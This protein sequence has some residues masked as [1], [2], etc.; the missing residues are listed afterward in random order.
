MQRQVIVCSP[1]PPS[2]RSP[3]P[4]YSLILLFRFLPFGVPSWPLTRDSPFASI[5]AQ[6]PDMRRHNTTS[7]LNRQERQPGKHAPGSLYTSHT[8]RDRSKPESDLLDA[9][10]TTRVIKHKQERGRL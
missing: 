2:V 3:S 7:L 4:Y 1:Y 9:N 5:V 8:L 10:S 6:K